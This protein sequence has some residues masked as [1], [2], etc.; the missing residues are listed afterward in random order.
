MATLKLKIPPVVTVIVA[1]TLMWLLA[2]TTPEFQFGI[3]GTRLI[4]GS[5]LLAGILVVGLGVAGFRSVKTTVNPRQ[6]Q[7]ASALVISGI[8]RVTRNPMYL[9]LLLLLAAWALAL[10]H[11]AGFAGVI[12]FVLYMNRYQIASEEAV[13][14]SLFGQAYIDYRRTVRRWL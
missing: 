8:Y 3:P 13:L 14:T 7:N 11:P 10:E 2:R 1:A 6:P 4:A 5:F 12:G 9:G